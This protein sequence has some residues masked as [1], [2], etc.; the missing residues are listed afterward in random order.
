MSRKFG[1]RIAGAIGL[2]AVL[3]VAGWYGF[4][5]WSRTKVRAE[6]DAV[7]AGIRDTGAKASFTDA[8]FDPKEMG[9]TVTGISIVSPDG[10]ARVKVDRLSARGGE[11]PNDR[12][13]AVDALDLDGVEIALT[14]EAA[15]G[16]TITYTLPQVMIDR[17]NGPL[18]LVAA[19]E[20]NGPFG[21]LRVALRQLAAT[22]AAKVTIPEAR[23]RIAPADAAPTEFTYRNLAAEGVN[24]GLIRSMV[25]DTIT[26]SF[27][28][29]PLPAA[30][31]GGGAKNA[32]PD[33]TAPSRAT[34]QID[35]YVA[36]Q[37]DTAPFL[38]MTQPGGPS[39]KAAETYG[40]IVGKVVTGP[41]KMT[42]E[43]GLT[44]GAQSI[45]LENMAIR[46]ASFDAQRIATFDALGRKAPDLSPEES[47]R[48]I[49]VTRDLVGGLAF[50]T[51]AVTNATSE[52]QGAKGKVATVRL[53]G[54]A[55]GVLDGATLEGVEGV[56]P[57]GG[58]AK[59]ARFAVRQLDFNQLTR[60]AAE[61]DAPSPLSA[62]VLFKV[63][64][65]V[66]MKGLEV[67]YGEGPHS[68]EPVKI[69]TFALSWGGSLGALPS[70]LDFT[71]ADVSGPIHADDGEPFTYLVGAGINRATISM[72]LKAAYDINDRTLT[73]APVTTEVKDAFRVNLESTLADVPDAAFTDAAGFV[74]ALPAVAAGPVKVTLTDLGLAKLMFAQMAA[75]SGVSEDE[76]RNEVVALAEDFAAEL[77]AVSPDAAVVG[78]AVVAFL[79]KPGTLTVTATPKGRVPLLALAG[80]DDPSV[81]LEAFNFSATATAP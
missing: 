69:G 22:T 20:G 26:F 49:E 39:G 64:S 45:L 55:N 9:I 76:Y 65:G 59:M 52:Q 29:P 71:L 1:L 27:P 33:K 61:A 63:F 19:G 16:G 43:N 72:G 21:A 34:A 46:P 7:F 11:R 60:L 54:L 81:V 3:C 12:R 58:A 48:F 31:I 57:G 17:Y 18:S 80:S 2:V 53:E 74:S 4:L 25:V 5:A 35:G 10:A 67:P 37:I 38:L 13:V 8:A 41:Y 40:R 75:A 62:L 56:T 77:E 68:S 44:Q 36:A 50:T 42:Q 79:R 51:Y 28:L 73:I 47:R 30:Q 24:A 23:G 15:A 66:E 14:G 6:V 78:A 70:Y 32:A